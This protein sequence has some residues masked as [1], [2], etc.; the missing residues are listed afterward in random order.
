M[1]RSTVH[2]STWYTPGL[3]L[4]AAELADVY[5]AFALRIVKAVE[6]TDG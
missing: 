1:F 6:E 4:D 3:E 5:A 2:S